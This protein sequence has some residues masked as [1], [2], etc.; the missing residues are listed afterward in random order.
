MT[1]VTITLTDGE[2]R[3]L[4]ASELNDHEGW[5]SIAATIRR[6]QAADRDGQALSLIAAFMNQHGPWNGADVCEFVAD[7]IRETGRHV[8]ADPECSDRHV[9][10][11]KRCAKCNAIL[12]DRHLADDE[13]ELCSRCADDAI[14]NT[15]SSCGSVDRLH[16]TDGGVLCDSCFELRNP[17]VIAECEGLC[18]LPLDHVG[19]CQ[20]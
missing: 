8:C 20:P 4:L 2:A 19:L 7:V 15:C 3:L 12:A 9:R 6:A 11:T 17:D 18:N 1:E 13:P 5:Q 10:P 14:A 16:D